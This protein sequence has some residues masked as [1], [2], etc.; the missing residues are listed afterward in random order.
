MRE[1]VE[2]PGMK[3]ST[4]SGIEYVTADALVIVTSVLAAVVLAYL[5][6]TVTDSRPLQFGVFVGIGV[7]VPRLQSGHLRI[8]G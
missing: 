1:V 2:V 5:M 7:F 6:G 8:Q 3:P 4:M